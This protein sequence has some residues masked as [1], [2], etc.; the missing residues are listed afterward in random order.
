MIAYLQV[1]VGPFDAVLFAVKMSVWERTTCSA[2]R[3]SRTSGGCSPVFTNAR[4]SY[5]AG[6]R[7]TDSSRELESTA[8]FKAARRLDAFRAVRDEL[9]RRLKLLFEGWGGAS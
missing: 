4:R 2:S 7:A 1:S 3:C 6:T 5:E 8:L 9:F